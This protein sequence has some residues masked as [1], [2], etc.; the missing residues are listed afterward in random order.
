MVFSISPAEINNAFK[1]L[2]TF[3][4]KFAIIINEKCSDVLHCPACLFSK[5]IAALGFSKMTC[6]TLY[7]IYFKR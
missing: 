5:G 6:V 2:L 7:K 1:Y 3:I 4:S